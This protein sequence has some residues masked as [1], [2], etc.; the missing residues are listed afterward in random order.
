MVA[1]TSTLSVGGDQ[2]DK[3]DSEER[4]HTR[5]RGI[6]NLILPTTGIQQGRVLVGN[7]WMIKLIVILR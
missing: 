7:I 1:R 3:V 5:G 2:I 6:L 4:A